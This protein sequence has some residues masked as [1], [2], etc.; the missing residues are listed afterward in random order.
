M[1]TNRIS[2]FYTNRQEP[3]NAATTDSKD[4]FVALPAFAAGGALTANVYQ[5]AWEQAQRAVA[6]KRQV[7]NRIAQWL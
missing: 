6:A 5:L 2:R 4:S 7:R 3:Q 1:H